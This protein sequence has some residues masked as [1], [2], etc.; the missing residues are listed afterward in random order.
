M[1]I[2]REKMETFHSIRKN[3]NFSKSL[4]NE[5]IIKIAK[6]DYNVILTESNILEI[7]KNFERYMYKYIN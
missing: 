1:Q 6:D 4:T 2:S 3:K 7:N 5:D